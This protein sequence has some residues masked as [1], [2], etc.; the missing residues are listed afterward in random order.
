MNEQEIRKA[1]EE[2]YRLSIHTHTEEFVL[3]TFRN[4]AQQYLAIEGFPEEKKG[5]YTNVSNIER[6]N[7]VDTAKM[8][9]K[10]SLAEGFN[11]ALHLCK[12]AHVKEIEEKDREI[13]GQSHLIMRVK[14]HSKILKDKISELQAKLKRMKERLSEDRLF[15]ECVEI[16]AH[17]TQYEKVRIGEL[18]ALLTQAIRKLLEGGN[19]NEM[20]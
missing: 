19:T 9:K 13:E 3:Q 16:L 14:A 8:L 7:L 6:A 20:S 1:V 17:N 15:V 5:I 12:L 2:S 10:V 18:S 4:L 11:H